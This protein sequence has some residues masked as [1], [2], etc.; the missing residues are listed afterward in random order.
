MSAPF[1]V[2]VNLGVVERMLDDVAS[3]CEASVRPAAQAGAQVLYDEVKRNVGRLKKHTGNLDR[4]IYQHYVEAKSRVGVSFYSVGASEKK[5]P[6]AH[7][8][9][10]GH[11]QRYEVS[12][13]RKRGRFITHKDRPLPRPVQLAAK[14]FIRPAIAHFERAMQAAR[15]RYIAELQSKGVLSS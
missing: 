15:E 9:E 12:F 3:T 2:T 4:S 13:D 8:V 6:H 7:L 1:S 5:A 11:L 10:Y 14:P